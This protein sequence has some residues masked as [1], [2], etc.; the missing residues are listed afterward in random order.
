MSESKPKKKRSTKK[1]ATRKK[2]RPSNY[3]AKLAGIICDEIAGGK[4]LRAICRKRSMPDKST[5]CR[6]LHRKEHFCDQYTRAMRTRAL[7]CADDILEIADNKTEDPKHR[8]IQIDARKWAAMKML[9]K[10]YGGKILIES[11]E[12]VEHTHS[13]NMVYK[14]A[15]RRAEETGEVDDAD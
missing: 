5:V 13:F 11:T 2:G 10:V 14:E 8:A 1:R 9:P 6:W 3:S 15:V 7:V 4:S 12:K